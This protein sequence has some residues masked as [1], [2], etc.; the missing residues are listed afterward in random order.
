MWRWLG[1]LIALIVVVGVTAV[2]MAPKGTP[3]DVASVG[4]QLIREYI[5]E[6]AKTRLPDVYQITMPLEGRM[7]PIELGEGDV[8][9]R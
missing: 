9:P 6:Q 8:G 5:E 4:R 3:V 7:L 1:I 2:A